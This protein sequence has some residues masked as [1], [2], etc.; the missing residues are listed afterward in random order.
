MSAGSPLHEVPVE[1]WLRISAE[2]KTEDLNALR[3]TCRTI[4][5][6]LFLAYARE[7]FSK[8]QFM[9]TE[10]SLQTLI[11]ISN[12][13]L[14]EHLKHVI[15]GLDRYSDRD[16]ANPIQQTIYREGFQ[17]QQALIWS[18]R[19]AHMLTTAFRNLKPTTIGIRDYNSDGR[20]SRD[21]SNARWASYGATTVMNQ[22]GVNIMTD[23]PS[24]FASGRDIAPYWPSQVFSLVLTALGAAEARP[25]SIEVLRRHRGVLRPISFY[26]PGFSYPTVVPVLRNL[27]TLFLA[28][29]LEIGATRSCHYVPASGGG[30][31]GSAGADGP[32]HN[33]NVNGARGQ[34]LEKCPDFPLRLFVAH[35]SNL[36]H[37]RINFQNNPVGPGPTSFLQWLGSPAPTPT[38][39]PTCL[40][41]QLSALA[42]APAVDPA[43]NLPRTIDPVGLPALEQLDLGHMRVCPSMFIR[44]LR[45]FAPTL[46]RV[47]LWRVVLQQRDLAHVYFHEKPPPNLWVQL[48]KKMRALPLQLEHVMIGQPMQDTPGILS[49]VVNFKSLV[50]Q[51]D[52]GR[53]AVPDVRA[54]TGMDWKRFV[55]ELEGD[56]EIQTAPPRVA[57]TASPVDT[58]NSASESSGEE[59]EEE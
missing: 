36:K 29:D 15:I 35:L 47:E 25:Q 4:E 23:S 22:T 8:K 6:C 18:G 45:K 16:F 11:D 30:S 21:G 33:V 5:S 43:T 28:L 54:Y 24:R 53:R 27:T 37:L 39:T 2:L 20:R 42:Y 59:S 56:L 3:L 41:A 34:D 12:S 1:L 26:L 49:C 19:A 57:V 17:G 10:H 46:K 9:L 58:G 31:T 32:S 14:A 52:E 50:A 44:I 13:R 48:L 40:D 51:A 7:F 38:P 55:E